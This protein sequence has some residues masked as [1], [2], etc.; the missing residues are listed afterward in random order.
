M[1]AFRAADPSA[2]SSAGASPGRYLISGA[3]SG[4]GR[5]LARQWAADGARIALLG[6]R[7]DPLEATAAICR[8]AGGTALVLPADVTDPEAVRGAAAEVEAA[9][10]GLDGLVNNAGLA[11]YG[12]LEETSLEEWQRI[13]AVNLTGPFLL[14]RAMV[15]LL[16]RGRSPGVVMVASTLG[17]VGLKRAGAYC[18]AKA[19]LVNF[20]RV[21]ALEYAAEGIRFNAV[22]P[23]VVDTVM[24]ATDRGDA[25]EPGQRRLELAGL[26]PLGRLAD[27]A[28][29]AAVIRFLLSPA[30][31]FI[32]GTAVTMDGGQMAGFSR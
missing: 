14:T 29:V 30:A 4:I 25:L 9:W 8:E 1:G 2:P 13:L 17:L 32:T 20:T 16:R 7:R 27:P 23:A 21:L 26:H 19:G 15:P 3:G 28:E 11:G 18:A 24:L 31:S 6:R 10:G 22:C 5:E 12:G